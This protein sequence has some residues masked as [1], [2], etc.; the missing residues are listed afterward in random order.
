MGRAPRELPRD[1]PRYGEGS[2]GASP[3]PIA[4]Q[5]GL[6]GSLPRTER[7]GGRAPREPPRGPIAVWGRAPRE[8]PRGVRAL[9]SEQRGLWESRSLSDALSGPGGA[10]VM[11]RGGR[12]IFGCLSARQR[13]ETAHSRMQRTSRWMRRSS[14]LG[15]SASDGYEESGA[16][17]DRGF[18]RCRLGAR[19]S[20]R[21]AD[22]P[23]GRPRVVLVGLVDEVVGATA[24]HHRRTVGAAHCCGPRDRLPP[25]TSS[26]PAMPSHHGRRTRSPH[27]L[28]D[29]RA[30]RCR[31]ERAR[32]QGPT[33]PAPRRSS[34]PTNRCRTSAARSHRC[35]PARRRR[36]GCLPFEAPRGRRSGHR[37]E[38]SSQTTSAR[39]MRTRAHHWSRA[40]RGRA[41]SSH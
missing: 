23:P 22:R 36:R 4:V 19:P 6:R 35:V 37:R 29:R 14:R 39:T 5:G 34:N 40:R 38:T 16:S 28:H 10:S 2:A 32:A 24:K 20:L 13:G 7:G 1:R 25:P 21:F 17:I 27:R 8:P 31:R 3:A 11:G 9:G 12:V 18:E 15:G 26:T 41:G 30:S 33:T